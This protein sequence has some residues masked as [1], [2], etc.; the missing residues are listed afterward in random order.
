MPELL[1]VLALV[2]GDEPEPRDAREAAEE[3]MW[4]DEP[5][6]A[7]FAHPVRERE[8]IAARRGEALEDLGG[9]HLRARAR[10]HELRRRQ[11]ERPEDGGHGHAVVPRA[12]RDLSLIHI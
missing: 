7:R 10:P 8:E 11:L 12:H 2:P 1:E 9:L 5:R 4:E 6:E 3:K